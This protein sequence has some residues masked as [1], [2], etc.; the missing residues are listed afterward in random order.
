MDP[1]TPKELE[2]IKLV[3]AGYSNKEI[4]TAMGISEHTVKFHVANL[5]RKLGVNKKV[6]IAACAVRQGLAQ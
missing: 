6:E 5:A 1:L 4:A 3:T 2:A